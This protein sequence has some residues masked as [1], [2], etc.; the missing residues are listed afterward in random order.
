MTLAAAGAGALVSFGSPTQAALVFVALFVASFF[1]SGSETAFFSM[2][3]IDLQR[4]D[5]NRSGD[6]RAL[7]LSDRKRSLIGTIL[8]GNEATNVAISAAGAA[9]LAALVP[10]YEWLNVVLVTVPLV[11]F[12]EITPKVVAVRANTTWAR[13]AAWP[14]TLLYWLLWLPRTLVE[15]IVFVIAW[16]FGVRGARQSDQLEE[17]EFLAL[18]D[19][20]AEAGQVDDLEREVIRAVFEFDDLAVSRVM[21]PRPDVIAISADISWEDLIT[22]CRDHQYSRLPVYD[23]DPENLVGV[24]LAKDLLPFRTRGIS[25]SG[26]RSLLLPASFVPPSKRAED[27]LREFLENGLHLAFVVDEHGTWTGIVT[28]DDLMAEIVGELGETREE[29]HELDN[30]LGELLVRANTDI[31]DLASETGIHLPEGD[32]NTVGGWVFHELGRLPEVGDTVQHLD[33]VFEVDAMDDRRVDTVRIA[34]RGE[35]A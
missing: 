25:P 7:W 1:F 26:L 16:V 9:V 15:M 8:M 11:L 35:T 12:S 14:L 23:G 22:L 28:L 30:D 33:H 20:G 3:K 5:E 6:R 31:E 32:Y 29:S 13:L 17:G 19:E 34:Y 2:Q 10:G 24:L 21:T 4:L 27:L 18:L